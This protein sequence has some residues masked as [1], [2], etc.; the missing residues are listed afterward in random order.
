MSRTSKWCAV[1]LL[2]VIQ[3]AKTQGVYLESWV[4][5]WATYS[6]ESKL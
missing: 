1:S 2:N 4:E 6:E 5:R 3:F